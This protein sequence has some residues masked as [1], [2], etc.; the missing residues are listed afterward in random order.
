MRPKRTPFDVTHGALFNHASK[1]RR[2]EKEGLNTFDIRDENRLAARE[3]PLPF[4]EEQPGAR[5]T[6]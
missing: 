4:T 3:G 1:N 2:S 6:T 5:R